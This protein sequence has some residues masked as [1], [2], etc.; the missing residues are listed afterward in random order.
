MTGFKRFRDSIYEVSFCGRIRNIK[1][2]RRVY[3]FFSKKYGFRYP[4][5]GLYLNGKQNTYLVHRIVA[6]VH[7][8][9]PYN[10]PEVNHK[11]GNKFNFHSANLEWSTRSEN[12]QHMYDNGLKKYRPLH[13]KGKFGAAHNRSK[14]VV[15]S[16]GKIYGSMSEA[17]RE[18][19]IAI[20][21]VHWAVKNNAPIYGNVFQIAV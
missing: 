19:K 20:S 14:A 1:T 2:K 4:E 8:D 11:D 21:S 3:Y 6:E 15:C 13:Y 9:N 10:K 17:A 7:C 5:V 16:N 12:I 18:L